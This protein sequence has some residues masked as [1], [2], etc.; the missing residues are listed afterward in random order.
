M[1]L[2]IFTVKFIFVL[3]NIGEDNLYSKTVDRA[4]RTRKWQRFP[5]SFYLSSLSVELST[6]SHDKT[7]DRGEL[8]EREREVRSYMIYGI[9]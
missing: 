7:I 8:L 9:R 3:F 5:P 2:K 6:K 4:P 1:L